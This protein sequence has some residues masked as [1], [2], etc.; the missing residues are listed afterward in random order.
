MFKEQPVLLN[1][2]K[3]GIFMESFV[4]L[5]LFFACTTAGVYNSE[6]IGK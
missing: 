2:V 3:M 5:S 1:K 6:K 4:V